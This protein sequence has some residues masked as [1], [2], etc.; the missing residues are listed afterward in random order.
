[1]TLSA[2]FSGVPESERPAQIRKLIEALEAA[3][4]EGRYGRLTVERPWSTHNPVLDGEFSC[5]GAI[6]WYLEREL[7]RLAAAG[8]RISAGPGRPA[9]DMHDPELAQAVDETRTDPRRKKLFL[10]G[11][12]R[13]AL[14][15][16]RLQHYT[17][18]PAEYFQRYVLLTNYSWHVS[19]FRAAL[20]DCVGPDIDDRQMPA[21]HYMLPD[22][23]G[24]T[25]VNIGVGP[26]NAKTITDHLAVLRPDLMLM[27][28]HCGGLRNHQEIGDLVLATA[29]LRDDRVL[30]EMLPL[31]VPIV[32]NHILNTLLLDELTARS[33]R[34]RMGVVFTTANRNWE[35]NLSS[36]AERLQLTR[37]IAVDM[38]SATVATNGF[39]YRIPTATLLAVSDKPLHARPKLNAEAQAFYTASRRQHVEIAIAVAGKARVLYP[40][41]LP[42]ADIRSSDEPLLGLT[43]ADP[44]PRTSGHSAP[45]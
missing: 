40:G 10:F 37:A 45:A 22:R 6:R 14:S 18:T 19:E 13:M 26:S 41:G 2:D 5:P 25:M 34:S 15:I 8:A 23:A 28:G 24:L 17:G 4:Q 36:V 11:P 3:G 32:S 12:E 43:E 31:S 39:R 29:Y 35:L 1:M 38:E 20:P 42:S 30:D 16:D 33:L 9:M 44:A 21:W 7:G 27:I